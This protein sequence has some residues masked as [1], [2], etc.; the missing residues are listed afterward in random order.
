MYGSY[1]KNPGMSAARI[2]AGLKTKNYV[3]FPAAAE[4]IETVY[5]DIIDEMDKYEIADRV[6]QDYGLIQYPPEYFSLPGKYQKEVNRL[7]RLELERRFNPEYHDLLSIRP[8]ETR[9][10]E[11]KTVKKMKKSIEIKPKTGTVKSIGVKFNPKKLDLFVGYM[12]GEKAYDKGLIRD[13]KKDLEFKEYQKNFSASEKRDLL[14][15]WRKGYD[16][17]KAL[18]VEKYSKGKKINPKNQSKKLFESFQ[19]R[20][21]QG[22]KK[23]ELND[24]TR[25]TYLGKI[26]AVEYETYKPH[27][28]NKKEVYRHDF[29]HAADLL[30]NG[31]ELIIHGGKIKINSEGIHG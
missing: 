21:A 9:P 31:K 26:I 7:V 18:P 29:D 17:K 20:A 11:I 10:E 19:G 23:I 5:D 12:F 6:Y 25:L 15:V 14:D 24:M 2:A 22:E 3:K 8:D 16:N 1:K 27:L 4:K 13:W 30:T 28:D